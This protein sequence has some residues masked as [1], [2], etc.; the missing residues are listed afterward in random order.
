MV[1]DDKRRLALLLDDLMEDH[2]RNAEPRT[3][4]YA[5]QGGDI[6][7]SYFNFRPSK[8]TIDQIDRLL[9][10]HYGLSDDELDF[11]I[12]YE[13]KYRMGVEEAG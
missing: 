13:I 6:T 9:A 10:G 3:I 7:V 1:A 4:Y 8:P 5:K 2:K 11:I 12:N